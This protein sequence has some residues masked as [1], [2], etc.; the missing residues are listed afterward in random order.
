MPR[1]DQLVYG[2]AGHE[3]LTFMDAYS[4]NIN[5]SLILILMITN[6]IKIVK[7]SKLQ[8]APLLFSNFNI[9]DKIVNTN[10]SLLL[11][12][13]ITNLIKID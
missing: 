9:I 2:T 10:I 13:M 6:L 3:L 5:I 7:G 1:I 12:L 11:I 4:I 8:L